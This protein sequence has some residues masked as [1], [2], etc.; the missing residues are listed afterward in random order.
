[1][2]INPDLIDGQIIEMKTDTSISNCYRRTIK[3]SNGFMINT[4]SQFHNVTATNNQW[5]GTYASNN[6][7]INNYLTAFKE[8]WFAQVTPRALANNHWLMAVNYGTINTP[9]QVQFLRGT[10]GTSTGYVDVVAYG[11]WK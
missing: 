7:T 10:S 6:Y 9:P 2:K 11:T 3:F 4:V 8:V 1:M 5:N